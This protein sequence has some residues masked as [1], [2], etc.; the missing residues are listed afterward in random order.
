[1]TGAINLGSSYGRIDADSTSTYVISSQ[2]KDT[3]KRRTLNVSNPST[4]LDC[5]AS[6]YD[7]TLS[8]T[9]NL[10]G[11]HNKVFTRETLDLNMRTY[12]SVTQL[13]LTNGSCTVNDC[14]NAMP[15]VSTLVT[16][17]TGVTDYPNQYGTIYI[18]KA[19]SQRA[20]ALFVGKGVLNGVYYKHFE[21]VD[22][23]ASLSSE[24]YQ[25]A[26]TRDLSSYLPLAGGVMTGSLKTTDVRPSAE[27]T[28]YCGHSSYPWQQ[29]NSRYFQMY[30]NDGTGY[31]YGRLFAHTAGT[32]SA[33][34]VGRLQLGNNTVSGTVG[35]AQG[36][37]IMYGTSS[38]YTSLVAGNNTT[39]NVNLTL[40]SV[41][42]KIPVVSLSG[43]TLTITT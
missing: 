40:P 19:G 18:V 30:N 43:T 25:V 6:I 20:Y 3:S 10:Y 11:E 29:V 27:F 37:I 17:A 38:G 5:A 26:L 15:A 23:V 9:Y 14:Y 32:T 35:N 2:D 7:S 36:S 34:G 31:I 42:G 24:W 41:T 28:S 33:V 1:M 21:T 8:K 39:S 12:T 22:N 4:D 16:A 13:G